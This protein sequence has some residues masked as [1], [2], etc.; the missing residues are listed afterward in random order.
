VLLAKLADFS[1]QGAEEFSLIHP[2]VCSLLRAD[3][4]RAD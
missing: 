3:S 1:T 2:P 4:P